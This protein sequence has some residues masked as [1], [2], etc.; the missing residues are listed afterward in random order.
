M[1][2]CNTYLGTRVQFELDK[3]KKEVQQFI[4]A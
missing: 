1:K 3:Y 2:N 4:F